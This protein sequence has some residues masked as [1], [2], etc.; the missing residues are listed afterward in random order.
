M[1]PTTSTRASDSRLCVV[2]AGALQR[3]GGGQKPGRVWWAWRDADKIPWREDLLPWVLEVLAADCGRLLRELPHLRSHH[4]EVAHFQWLV[5]VK[6]KS[7]ALWPVRD[8]L[9]SCFRVFFG[10]SRVCWTCTTT[11]L[12]PVLARASSLSLQRSG[13]QRPSLFIILSPKLSGVASQRVQTAIV[14]SGHAFFGSRAW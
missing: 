8:N 10:V 1:T 7:P 2:E 6:Y 13:S 14:R 12:P 11:C 3:G 9:I 5:K 4:L